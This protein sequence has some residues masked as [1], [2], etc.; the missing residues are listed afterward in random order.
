MKFEKLKEREFLYKGDIITHCEKKLL[1][2]V[3]NNQFEIDC[4]PDGL[5]KIVEG[6]FNKTTSKKSSFDFCR[7]SK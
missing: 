2:I 7:K 4:H 1:S 6:R 5:I 3:V